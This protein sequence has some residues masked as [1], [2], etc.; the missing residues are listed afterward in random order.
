MRTS[1]VV[2]VLLALLLASCD[3]TPPAEKNPVPAT[4]PAAFLTLHSGS[5]DALGRDDTLWR[6]E[7][8]G[9]G[10]TQV[11]VRALLLQDGTSQTLYQGQFDVSAETFTGAILALDTHGAAFGAEGKT[12]FLVGASLEPTLFAGEVKSSTA[13][14]GLTEGASLWIGPNSTT[15]VD[16]D[17]DTTLL[18][19]VLTPEDSATH[20]ARL[21]PTWQEAMKATEQG[22]HVTVVVVLSWKPKKESQP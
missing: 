5:K 2:P 10:A 3:S 20:D 9:K 19:I 4:E 6:F 22:G 12:S 16:P 14:E 15:A 17:T 21:L 11:T 7:L 8:E 18:Q 1:R 13:L